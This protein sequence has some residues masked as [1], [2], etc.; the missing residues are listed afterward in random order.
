MQLED[1]MQKLTVA[2]MQWPNTRID[3]TAK[4]SARGDMQFYLRVI[5]E[6]DGELREE[7]RLPAEYMELYTGQDVSVARM[8]GE[9]DGMQR[10][11][12]MMHPEKKQYYPQ[13]SD[14]TVRAYAATA[15]HPGNMAVGLGQGVAIKGSGY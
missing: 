11:H 4:R 7:I 6:T 8:Q 3:I 2:H 15:S 10:M 12:D 14:S 1:L 5:S 13:V 9:R